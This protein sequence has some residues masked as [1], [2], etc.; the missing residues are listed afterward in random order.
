MPNK[1]IYISE[2]DLPLYSRAQELG[3]GNLSAAI[4]AALR[5]FI[6]VE[7]GRLEGLEEITVRVGPGVG[8]KQR[9]TGVLLAELGRTSKQRVE[10]FRV[11]RSRTGKFVVHTQR[12]KEYTWAGGSEADGS[13]SGWR[14]YFSSDQRWG[15]ATGLATLEVFD[16]LEALRAAVP[17]ELYDMVAATAEQPT[18]EDL[19]I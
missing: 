2:A 4:A 15:S 9:F 18:I 19:D 16:S 17:V 10:E 7:E 5:R 11:Y 1:T 8:R 14:R 6:D 3:G 12:S 13:S